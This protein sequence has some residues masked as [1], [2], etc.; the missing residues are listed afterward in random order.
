MEG[1]MH[2]SKWE[3]LL[4][5]IERQFGFVEHETERFDERRLT[6][7]TVVF[8]GAGGRMK[9]ERSVRPVVL[10]RKSHFAKR[11]GSAATVEY[12]YS[13]TESV[14]TVRLFQWDRLARDWRELELSALVK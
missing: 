12:V 2:Q 13:D 11:V 3:N 14:D 9:L 6:V 5:Q 1:S 7:E 4:D 8:D 10:D